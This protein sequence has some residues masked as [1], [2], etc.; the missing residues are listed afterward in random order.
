[1]TPSTLGCQHWDAKNAQ[2]EDFHFHVGGKLFQISAH[3]RHTD[4]STGIQDRRIL[5][6][7]R[8][9]LFRLVTVLQRMF[10]SN[11]RGPGGNSRGTRGNF[12]LVKIRTC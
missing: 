7:G 11:L 12:I 8:H 1:M 4:R 9:A 5:S 10:W 2:K 6:F 3:H